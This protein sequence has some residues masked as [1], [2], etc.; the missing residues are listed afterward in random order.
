MKLKLF[1]E[2]NR[3][4]GLMDVSE[5][6]QHIFQPTGHS[7]GPTCIK[8][9]GDFIKGDV[10]SIDDICMS[11]G[12]DWVVGTPP[13][14]MKIGLDKL[15]IQYKEHIS[16]KEPFQSIKNVIDRSN[17][18]IVRTITKN[19]PHWIVIDDYNDEVFFVNDPWLG[20]IKY[21]EEE[22]SEIWK[23]R[24]FFFYEIIT[25]NQQVIDDVKIRTMNLSDIG[26]RI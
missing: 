26:R 25:G 17:V 23:I 4:K 3:I 11:C 6:V 24:D 15:G 9:V 1:E 14:K 22:L 16:E 12:T 5:A 18:A 2:I 8:M 7:C 10:P 21:T 19:T 20:Q 13:E